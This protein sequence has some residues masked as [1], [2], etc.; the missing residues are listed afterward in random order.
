LRNPT[1][2]DTD[3]VTALRANAESLA[4][5]VF[6]PNLTYLIRLLS[7]S[8]SVA[9]EEILRIVA[10][11]NSDAVFDALKKELATNPKTCS[12]VLRLLLW[13]LKQ[14]KHPR[15]EVLLGLDRQEP[16]DNL[17]A[18]LSYFGG[19]K[20]LSQFQAA[21]AEGSIIRRLQS[22]I[23]A[24]D[25]ADDQVF[26][27]IIALPEWGR[28]VNTLQHVSSEGGFQVAGQL[29][30]TFLSRNTA[31]DPTHSIIVGLILGDKTT[32]VR[33]IVRFAS[34]L[35]SVPL[36]RADIEKVHAAIEKV[37]SIP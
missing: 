23:P 3:V 11:T 25:A 22:F 37:L 2:T 9:V 7:T 1:W 27:V 36:V 33:H 8:N 31:A 35:A 34:H 10:A 24:L 20:L 12:G 5:G 17:N 32:D 13:L 6:V 28:I 21:F 26:D 19:E 30:S 14:R 16:S 29:I 15:E 4:G 18:L